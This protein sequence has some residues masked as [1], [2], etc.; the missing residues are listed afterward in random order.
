MPS[1]DSLRTP[2]CATRPAN[3]DGVDGAH[4]GAGAADFHNKIGA[5]SAGL[6]HHPRVPVLALAIV[7]AGIEAQLP[8]ALQLGIAARCAQH[9]GAE[10]L[11]KL[12]GEDGN[13]AGSLDDGPY[14]RLARCRL[15]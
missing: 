3:A 13:T 2:I 8:R 1:E 5:A 11:G 7:H 15:R 9:A 12:Q 14:R 6:L 10:Q 4:E